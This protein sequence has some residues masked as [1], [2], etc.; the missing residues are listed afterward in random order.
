MRIAMIIGAI[1]M[2]LIIIQLVDMHNIAQEK[3]EAEQELK[4][5]KEFARR[6]QAR[7]EERRGEKT[8]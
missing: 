7:I 6:V 4:E 3:K 5:L 2:A 8:L 1:L